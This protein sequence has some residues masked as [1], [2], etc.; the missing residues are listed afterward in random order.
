MSMVA[1]RPKRIGMSLHARDRAAALQFITR[2]WTPADFAGIVSR[3]RWVDA[4]HLD[5]INEA[6][7]RIARGDLLRLMVNL[8]PRHG[9]SELI[10]RYFPAWYLGTFPDRRVILCS[11]EADFAAQWGRRARDVLEE[12]GLLFRDRVRVDQTSSAADRWD[13]KG[14]QGGMITA[15]VRGPITGKGADVLII[16]DPVKNA[17]EA[18]SPTYREAAWEWYKSTAYTRLEPGGAIILIQT[19]WHEEDLSGKLLEEMHQ[20]GGEQWEIINLPALAEAGDPLGRQPGEALWPVRFPQEV[21]ERKKIAVGSYFWA[22]LYQGKPAP[23]GGNLFKREWFRIVD[24]YPR[25]LLAE[26]RWDLAASSGKGDWTTGLQLGIQDGI[27]YVIDVR[28]DRLSPAGGEALVRQTAIMD[29]QQGLGMRIRMEQEPGASGK[30]T[31]DHFRKRVLM[32]FDFAGHPSTGSKVERA[33]PV[34]A[35]AEAGNVLLLRGPWNRVFLD[36]VAAFPNGAHDDIV[37][38]LSGAFYD[39]TLGEEGTIEGTIVYDSDYR[40]SPI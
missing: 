33:R 20:E 27:A 23:P 36:E 32:G 21:L 5:L 26:R 22:A 15:G 18:A 34:R 30:Y 37:D 7:M 11:Y 31:I 8:P 38:T 19:R 9:K 3:D 2:S 14:H 16:D 10:S 1:R 28:R 35:A 4:P 6:L 40:I 24:D 25:G 29:L 39:L 12:F 13:F 17:E